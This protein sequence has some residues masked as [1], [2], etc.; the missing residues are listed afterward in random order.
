MSVYATLDGEISDQI[1][2]N[3]GYGDFGRWVDGLDVDA[4]PQLVHLREHGWTQNLPDFRQQL[5]QALEENPPGPD[6]EEM[7]KGLSDLLD[8][9]DAEVLTVSEGFGPGSE[10]FAEQPHGSF[11]DPKVLMGVSARILEVQD[12]RQTNNYF[13]GAAATNT[14][15]KFLGVDEGQSVEETAEELGTTKAKSTHPDAIRDYFNRRG[16]KVYALAGM[17]V[18][19]LARWTNR[20][21]PVIV[22]V[23]DY[24]DRR[25]EGASFAYGHYLTVI[26]VVSQSPRYVICQDSSLENWEK[27]KGGDV[28]TGEEQEGNIDALGRIMVEEGRWMKVWHDVDDK[29]RKFVRYGIVVGKAAGRA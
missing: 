5:N 12:V 10:E 21:C 24:G 16:C 23:Q 1:A 26:G 3:G 17:T 29:G 28:P 4:F 14:V 9:N 20:G 8:K 13:C 2:S 6:T 11:P 15:A 22:P 7:A 19:G 18:N 25:E 27:I